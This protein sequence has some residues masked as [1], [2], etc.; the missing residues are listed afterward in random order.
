MI[1]YHYTLGFPKGFNPDVGTIP[2]KYTRHAVEASQNDKYGPIKLPGALDTGAAKCI[3]V[4]LD[5]GRVQKLVYRMPQ[6]GPCDL[7]L[8][9]VPDGG[10]FKVLTVWKN[11]KSDQHETLQV[12]KYT[13]A[14]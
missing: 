14:A 5:G 1:I 13:R 7:V 2:L 10:A 11:L 4:Y 8:V 6:L 9:V 12:G 3:E